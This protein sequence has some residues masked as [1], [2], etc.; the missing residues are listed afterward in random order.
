METMDPTT[1]SEDPADMMGDGERHPDR[2]TEPPDIPE[3]TRVEN[4]KARVKRV[5]ATRDDGNETRQPHKPQ[6]PP[7]KAEAPDEQHH[8]WQRH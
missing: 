3:S 4:G 6:E 1:P 8:D 5:E 2:P 7:D